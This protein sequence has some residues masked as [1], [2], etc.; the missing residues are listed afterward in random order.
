MTRSNKK[1]QFRKHKKKKVIVPYTFPNLLLNRNV[2]ARINLVWQIDGTVLNVNLNGEPDTKH[3]LVT[4]VD[5]SCGKLVMSKVFYIGNKKKSFTASSLIKALE[6]AVRNEGINETLLI[7][8]DRGPQFTS[9]EYFQYIESHPFLKGSMTAGGQP[10]Q[11]AV[12]ERMIRTFKSQLKHLNVDLPTNVKRT[13]D[14][15]KACDR[16]RIKIN[17]SA[18]HK[19]NN[20]ETVDKS[21]EQLKNT[22]IVEP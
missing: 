3:Y 5:L 14:L 10:N 21:Y 2:V 8:S 9:K 20:G 11:N 4:A 1:S 18:L 13:R 19:R 22:D 7:H 12:I 15:Q 16:R 17:S 6:T